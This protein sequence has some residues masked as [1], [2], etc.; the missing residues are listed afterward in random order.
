ME[1]HMSSAANQALGIQ[2]PTPSTGA[3]RLI[4][5]NFGIVY[6]VHH[7]SASRR[8]QACFTIGEFFV[9]LG[10]AYVFFFVAA[11]NCRSGALRGMAV[12]GPF[13][14]CREML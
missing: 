5:R 13:L 3:H 4:V 14:L 8:G 10:Y 1:F 6:A 2:G 7:W 11:A 12:T 9:D